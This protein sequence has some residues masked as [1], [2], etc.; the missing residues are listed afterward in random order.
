MVIG[1]LVIF[2]D[3]SEVLDIE[4]RACHLTRRSR[5]LVGMLQLEAGD[6][7]WVLS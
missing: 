3:R 2:T 1:G 7:L 5:A 4:Q 6:E